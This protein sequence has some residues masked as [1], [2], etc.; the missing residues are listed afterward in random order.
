MK[1]ISNLKINCNLYNWT[2][3]PTTADSND[4]WTPT[5]VLLFQFHYKRGQ[6]KN[7]EYITEVNRENPPNPLNSHLAKPRP[8]M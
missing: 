6:L 2:I 1:Y 5:Q 7:R 8:R 4:S 3:G